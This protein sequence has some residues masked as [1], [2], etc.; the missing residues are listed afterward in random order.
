MT[1]VPMMESAFSIQGADRTLSLN[2]LPLPE[3]RSFCIAVA[4]IGVGAK[5]SPLLSLQIAQYCAI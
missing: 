4:R 2:R 1:V 3:I 5:G